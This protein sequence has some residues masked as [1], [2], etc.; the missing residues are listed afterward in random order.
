M[1]KKILSTEKDLSFINTVEDLQLEARRL[2]SKIR[3]QEDELREHLKTLPREAMKAGVGNIVQPLMNNKMA[4]LALTAGSALVG[5]FFVKKAAAS[6]TTAAFSSFKKAGVLALGK[7]AL[8][9][10]FRPKKKK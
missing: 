8:N 2:R 4:G 7:V 1:E 10:L 3:L 9:W 6:A 5:N